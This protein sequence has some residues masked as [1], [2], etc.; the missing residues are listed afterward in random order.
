LR[1]KLKLLVVLNSVLSLEGDS[2]L[3]SFSLRIGNVHRDRAQILKW[4]AEL[5]EKMFNR[6][7]RLYRTDFFYVLV[8]VSDD[9]SKNTKNAIISSGS[10]IRPELML[11]ISEK[12]KGANAK[13]N[14]QG[15]LHRRRMF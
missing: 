13:V 4:A 15:D 12:N 5:D 3:R 6:Q 9:L 14:R 8:K 1:E 7:F 2:Q 11:L 10:P